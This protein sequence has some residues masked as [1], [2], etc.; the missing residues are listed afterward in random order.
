MCGI[1]SIVGKQKGDTI[2]KMIKSMSSRGPDNQGI[3][4]LG[5]VSFG[6]ARL[7]I[8]DT[9]TDSNQPMRSG[10]SL[11]IY[12]GEIYSNAEYRS[13]TL[14]LFDV[15]NECKD[16]ADVLDSLNGMFAFGYFAIDEQKIYLARDRFGIK[17]LYYTLQDDYF[18][19]ASTPKAVS[20]TK[21]N[22][23]L[24]EE[25]LKEYLSLGATMNHSL[26]AGIEAVPPGHYLIYDIDTHSFHVKQW[27]FPK[28]IENAIDTIEQKVTQAI[29]QVK[30]TCD[31]PQAV[32]LSGGVDSTLVSSRYKGQSAIHL[33]SPEYEYAKQVSD[34]FD[35]NLY[36]ADPE[37][38]SAEACLTDYVTKCGDASMAALIPY[39]ACKEINRLGYKVAITANGAD[40]LFYGYDRMKGP[41]SDQ[42]D[43]IFRPL[44]I[45]FTKLYRN[46]AQNI[47]INYY[48]T[49]DL[50]KTLDFASMCHSI[51]VRVPYLDHKLVE[52]AMSIR[53]D[54]HLENLGNKSI[55]KKMLHDLGFDWDFIHRP[56]IGFSLHHLPVD[57]KSLQERAM[58][59]YKST[60]YPQLPPTTTGRQESYH[61]MT[62]TCL[63]VFMK[64]Y[65][66]DFQTTTWKTDL[67]LS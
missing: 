58:K 52:A 48:L 56:K 3:V 24:S 23:K 26:F 38:E 2:D 39:I 36:V 53:A 46:S 25:G 5:N 27:Y 31:W 9:S 33:R 15:L 18:A 41:V 30:L 19:F 59:W 63:Y 22:W 20:L 55:L 60:S 66:L 29:D 14:K 64:V 42:I 10:A 57:L 50:N 54:Q 1:A 49:H 43:S 12:N 45:D 7:S 11:M 37:V 35:M 44:G 65:K 34:K 13:D 40:E 32:L 4:R 28:F 67:A 16:I 8:V 51:E 6:H 62:I 47:E 21:E 17:P 61:E